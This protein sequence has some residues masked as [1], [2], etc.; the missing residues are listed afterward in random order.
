LNKKTKVEGVTTRSKNKQNKPAERER[1]MGSKTDQAKQLKE[2]TDMQ[3][4]EALAD[5]K[6]VL[7]KLLQEEK[8]KSVERI[9][10]IT[11]ENEKESRIDRAEARADRQRF[12]DFIPKMSAGGLPSVAATASAA[13]TPPAVARTSDYR[14]NPAQPVFNGLSSENVIDWID[15]TSANLQF[16]HV[17]VK[18]KAKVAGSYLRTSAL[19]TFRKFTSDFPNAT[20]EQLQDALK[21]KFLPSNNES[22]MIGKFHNLKQGNRTVQEYVD[23]YMKIYTQVKI[24]SEANKEY[25]IYFFANGLC[26]QAKEN[27][28]QRCPKSVDEAIDFAKTFGDSVSWQEKPITQI[29]RVEYEASERKCFKC[30]LAGHIQRDC[31]KGDGNQRQYRS[32]D[33]QRCENSG[34][35][36]GSDR[37]QNIHVTK[38]R[39]V[40]M[41]MSCFCCAK[42]GHREAQCDVKKQAAKYEHVRFMECVKDEQDEMKNENYDDGPT[43]YSIR[44]YGGKEDASE[45]KFDEPQTAR[46][47]VI[48]ST[49]ASNNV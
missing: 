25:M 36:Q 19:G 39:Q 2:Q 15:V 1:Q 32:E 9:A 29:N 38:I 49:R 11:E 41:I 22:R 17:E 43:C 42:P 6:D 7:E 16:S 24:E 13:P 21:K 23:E 47:F 35:Y 37:R 8:M 4:I 3:L 27:V 12:A 14:L 28:K 44:S 46:K 18:D 30:G 40:E 26:Q 34:Q 5:E 48:N 10:T 20:W 33:N 45:R 31:T